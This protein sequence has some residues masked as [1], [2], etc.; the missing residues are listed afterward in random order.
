MEEKVEKLIIDWLKS[1][2]DDKLYCIKTKKNFF[3]KNQTYNIKNIENKYNTLIYYIYGENLVVWN[4][5]EKYTTENH[6]ELWKDW[7][8]KDYFCTIN[9]A[10]KYK[11]KKISQKNT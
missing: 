5:T 9:E 6:I 4:F 3:F 8:L 1:E 2:I 7:I 10:R 11:L